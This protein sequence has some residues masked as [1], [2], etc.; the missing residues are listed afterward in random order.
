M[1]KGSPKVTWTAYGLPAGLA[2]N[3]ST[4]VLSGT[5]TA[6]GT[7]PVYVYVVERGG[8]DVG[9]SALSVTVASAVRG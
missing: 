3:A 1:A 2:L 4:G 5:P 7:F 9:G 8:H 6:T